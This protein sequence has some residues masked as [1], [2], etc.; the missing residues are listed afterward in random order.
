MSYTAAATRGKTLVARILPGEDLI[1][2]IIECCREHGVKAGFITVC[3]GSL[4]KASFV[5]AVENKETYYKMVY[6]EAQKLDG[7]FEFLGGQGLVG[8]DEHDGWQVHLHASFCDKDRN[9]LA[10][11]M[12]D[13]GNLVLATMEVV[14]QEISDI[15]LKRIYHHQSGFS[16]FTPLPKEE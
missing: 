11:H 4:R 12:L 10:G 2:S 7:P 1:P 8:L 9:V 5:Y 13:E 16:F 15:S 3:I 14:I 6:S